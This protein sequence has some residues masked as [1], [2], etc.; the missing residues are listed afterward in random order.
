MPSKEA[1]EKKK[2]FAELKEKAGSARAVQRDKL[3]SPYRLYFDKEGNI[4][5][6]TKESNTI[7]INDAWLTHDFEQ[8]QI[9]IL[10]GKNLARYIV[11]QDPNVDGVYSIE[12]KN[13]DQKVINVDNSF[14]YHLEKSNNDSENFEILCTMSPKNLVVQLTNTVKEEYRE[15]DAAKAKRKNQKVLYFYITAPNDPHVLFQEIEIQLK[16]LLINNEVNIELQKNVSGCSLYT[17][18]IFD[19]YKFITKA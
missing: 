15:V 19:K 10:K 5:S 12:L 4:I 1:L 16:E 8:D 18:K 14:L 17:K 7:N 2:K 9:Q 6:L 13:L 11:V 3:L